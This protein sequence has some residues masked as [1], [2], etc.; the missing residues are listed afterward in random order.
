MPCRSIRIRLQHP[1]RLINLLQLLSSLLSQPHIASKAVRMP[2]LHQ[3]AI[4]LFDLDRRR[5]RSQRQDFKCLVRQQ[6]VS[7]CIR[8][9]SPRASLFI[10]S[11]PAPFQ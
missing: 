7:L 4:R 3:I 11:Y 5:A 10:A 9:Q 2:H 6:A 8:C 1:V